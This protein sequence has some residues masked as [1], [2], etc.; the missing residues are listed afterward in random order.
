MAERQ[1]PN[2]VNRPHG[3]RFAAG[4]AAFFDAAAARHRQNHRNI[5]S[6]HALL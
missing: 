1:S 2:G 3:T 5:T 6:H 4:L